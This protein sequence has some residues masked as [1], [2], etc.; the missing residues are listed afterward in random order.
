VAVPL[1][2]QARVRIGSAVAELRELQRDDVEVLE[3]VRDRVRHLIASQLQPERLASGEQLVPV[4]LPLLEADD[5]RPAVRQ[6]VGSAHVDEWIL[7]QLSVADQSRHATFSCA[8][9]TASLNGSMPTRRYVSRKRDRK[10]TRLN[11]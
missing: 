2:Q 9:Y 5:D 8:P 10:S 1:A 11:S 4:R 3:V 7:D 6:R